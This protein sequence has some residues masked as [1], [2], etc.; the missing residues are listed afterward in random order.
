MATQYL[1]RKDNDIRRERWIELRQDA[2]YVSVRRYDNGR[3]HV[4]VEW[5]G[6]IDGVQNVFEAYKK[7]FRMTVH[8]YLENGEMV[9]DA[10]NG[11]TWHRNEAEAIAHYE[12]F[13]TS[14]T[15]SHS[16]GGKFVEEGNT[17]KPINPDLPDSMIVLP[18]FDGDAAW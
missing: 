3:V 6:K 15:E 9:R 4:E 7:V 14:W 12:E 8:N 1:D 11:E 16:N 18:G 5:Y 10:L 13:L 2:A 17:L